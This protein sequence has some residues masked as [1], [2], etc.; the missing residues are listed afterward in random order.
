MEDR[1]T[2]DDFLQ[3]INIQDVLQDAGYQHYRKDGLKYPSYIRI[4]SDGRKVSGDKFL[5]N[6]GG[7]GCFQPPEQKVYN[8]ISFIKEHPDLFKDYHPGRIKTTWS[9]WCAIGCL[10]IRC[11][12]ERRRLLFRI[13]IANRSICLTMR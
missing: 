8:V 7:W 10:I 9:M 2:Y 1:L 12:T 13:R 11:L 4:G 5:V 3:R 6:A